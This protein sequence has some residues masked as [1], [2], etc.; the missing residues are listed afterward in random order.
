[1]INDEVKDVVEVE[2]SDNA[3]VNK[4]KA[5]KYDYMSISELE[6]IYEKAVNTYLDLTYPLHYEIT[7]IPDDKPRAKAWIKDCMEEII[8]RNGI[9]TTSY[10]ENGMSITWSSDMISDILRTRIVPLAKV[11]GIRNA[12]W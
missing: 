1:M 5:G 9:T 10:S 4:L 2:K 11:R 12:N 3:L 7:E 6:D 8:E